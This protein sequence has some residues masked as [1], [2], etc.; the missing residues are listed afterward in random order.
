MITLENQLSNLKSVSD[1]VKE[2][3]GQLPKGFITKKVSYYEH[4]EGEDDLIVS[5]I[6]VQGKTAYW[7]MTVYP[8]IDDAN[9][10][11]YDCDVID[12]ISDIH[13]VAADSTDAYKVYIADDD[14]IIDF[15]SVGQRTA[16]HIAKLIYNILDFDEESSD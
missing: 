15:Y 5:E 8:I 12:R 14:S 7:T 4:D 1:L 10:K 3:N 13:Y 9:D 11:C 16:R 2:I 6:E